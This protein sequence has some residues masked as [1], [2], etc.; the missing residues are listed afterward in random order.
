MTLQKLQLY[1]IFK[2]EEIL[3]LELLENQGFCNINYHLKTSKKSYVLREFKSDSTVNIS[4]DFEFKIQSKAFKKGIAARPVYFDTNKEFMIYEFQDGNHKEK[5]EKSELKDLVKTL[6]KLH[7]IKANTKVMN[8]K[9]QLK[10]YSHL[11]S[12]EAKKSLAICKGELKNLEKYKKNIVLCHHDL[13]PKN[14]LFS[15]NDI[16]FIDWEYAGLND[17]FFDLATICFE[18]KLVKK[19]QKY[20]L[21]KYLENY[22]K[23]DMSKLESY[24]KIY[25]HICKLW[26]I[27][28]SKEE[29]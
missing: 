15:K 19:E 23:K 18:F 10:F 26:F 1:N 12:K 3:S 2:D 9:Q 25:K 21:K 28:L 11:N 17:A 24:I 8:L 7:N 14:I 27:S 5:L 16:R 13:N 20:L 6:K 29:S 22:T 4:R